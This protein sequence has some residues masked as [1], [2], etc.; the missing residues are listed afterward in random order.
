MYVC[1]I[2]PVQSDGHIC[3][4]N[5]MVNLILK[6]RRRDCRALPKRVNFVQSLSK[7]HIWYLHI[8]KI[9]ENTWLLSG[10]VVKSDQGQQCA[11]LNRVCL[12]W[13]SA[14]QLQP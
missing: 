1:V 6:P 5:H 12:A 2:C 8:K 4:Y 9:W 3:P 7:F 10:H 11:R 14:E 13:S